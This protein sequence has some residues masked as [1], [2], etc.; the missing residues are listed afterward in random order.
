[1]F[2]T[3]EGPEGSG[4]TTQARLL[5][6]AFEHRGYRVTLTREPGGDPVSEQIRGI[7]LDGDDDSVTDRTEVFL[8]LAGRA[9]HTERVIRPS[10]AEGKIVICDR[11][12]D[13]TIAYQGYGSGFDIS[14]LRVMNDFATDGLTPDLTFLLDIDVEAGLKRQGAK[15]RIE[16]K[17]L[18]Y[19]ERVRQGFLKEAEL[20][21]DRIVVVDASADIYTVHRQVLQCV[22][23]V[24]GASI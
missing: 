11:F 16:R 24:L 4:K 14:L 6:E 5:A 21:P 9:Q 23:E 13:S 3:F 10:L 19:H 18:E 17:T 2:I 15:N 7:L 12:T 22:A 1:M 8:Y 20:Y